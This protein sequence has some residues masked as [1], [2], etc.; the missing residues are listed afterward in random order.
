MEQGDHR[1]FS[2]FRYFL[3]LTNDQDPA[4]PLVVFLANERCQQEN[5]IAQLK[6]GEGAKRCPWTPC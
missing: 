3:D 5:L 1:L 6:H 2:Q 4:A